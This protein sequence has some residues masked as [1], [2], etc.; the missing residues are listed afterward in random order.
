MI[1]TEIQTAFSNYV[2][3]TVA[4]LSAGEGSPDSATI[5][6]ERVGILEGTDVF[7]NLI[8]ATQKLFQQMVFGS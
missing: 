5:L 3:L 1:T 4:E 6:L 2:E 7:R 8:D